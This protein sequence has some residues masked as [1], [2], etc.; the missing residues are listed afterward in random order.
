LHLPDCFIAYKSFGTVNVQMSMSIGA[1]GRVK[2][3][4]VRKAVGAN[5]HALACLLEV[6]RR[7]VISDFK[8]SPGSLECSFDGEIINGE[9]RLIYDSRY[10]PSDATTRR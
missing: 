7:K 9:E 10:V 3:T 2:G 5:P 1:D 6:A 4:R 8:G